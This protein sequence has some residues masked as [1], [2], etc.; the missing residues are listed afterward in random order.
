M[1]QSQHCPVITVGGTNGKG[2][3]CALLEAIYRAAGY[4]VGV[5]SSPHLLRY[6]ERVRIDGRDASDAVLVDAFAE[7]GAAEV[8]RKAF[9]GFQRYLY[10]GR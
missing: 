9:V 1:P 5:Y 4:R 6:N 2:T 10:H 3:T 7:L 8:V